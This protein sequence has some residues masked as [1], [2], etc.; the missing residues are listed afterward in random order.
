[1]AECGLGEGASS[2]PVSGS[3]GEGLAPWNITN[4]FPQPGQRHCHGIDNL[5]DVGSGRGQGGGPSLEWC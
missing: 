3:I 4:P 2:T 5:G 1:M